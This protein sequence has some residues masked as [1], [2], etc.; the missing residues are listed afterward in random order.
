MHSHDTY[1]KENHLNISAS[2]MA[3]VINKSSTYVLNR[4]K[5]MELEVPQEIKNKFKGSKG[6]VTVF[7]LEQDQY[8][9]DNYLDIPVKQMARHL[10]ISSPVVFKRLKKLQLKV[11]VEISL[12]RKRKNLFKPG[13]VPANKGKKMK[14]FLHPEHI[15]LLKKHQFKKGNEPHNTLEDGVIRKRKDTRT[16]RAYLYIRVSKGNWKLLQREVY[17]NEIGPLKKSEVV[18]FKN[19]NTLD[20]R[21]ENLQKISKKENMQRNSIHRYGPEIAKAQFLT[22]KIERTIKNKTT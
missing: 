17:R 5:A 9:K 18:I 14:E 6:A 12:S 15:Q 3:K 20:C 10:E 8:L 16:G 7:T 11:P 19:G 2:K 4:L 1:I 13:H 22:K 21:P